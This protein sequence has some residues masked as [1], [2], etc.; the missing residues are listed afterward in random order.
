MHHSSF[1][2]DNSGL[3]GLATI[4]FSQLVEACPTTLT[5]LVLLDLRLTFN[6]S[7]SSQSSIKCLGFSHICLEPVLA[8]AI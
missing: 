4:N 8:K 5:S 1:S 3:E 7:T 6:E 2:G